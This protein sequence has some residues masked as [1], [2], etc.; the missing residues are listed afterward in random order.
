M[1]NWK[2]IA[3]GSLLAA[4]VLSAQVQ[5][6]TTPEEVFTRNLS[7]RDQMNKEFTPHK[8]IGN[9]YYV[10]TPVLG[11]YLV[12]TPAGLILI[13]SDYEATVPAIKAEVEKLGFKF[14]DIK[15]LLGSH[16]HGDHM[17]GDA[18]V[19]ELSGAQVV[20][21]AEDVPALR[22]IKPGGKEHPIDRIIHDG[23][24]VT[25][26]GTTLTAHLTPGHTKGCTTWTL[27]AEEGG[28]TYDVVIIGSAGVNPGV[29][30]VNNA[31]Y[32][33]IADDFVHTYAT[34]RSLPC[35]VPL[36]SHPAMFD[37]AGKFAK[38]QAGGPNP[39][40]DPSG[41]QIEIDINDQI[42]WRTLAAQRLKAG[43]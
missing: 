22:A 38:L 5:V 35:D 40:I 16:A 12:S 37:L 17:E 13:N 34:L 6:P 20:A 21:M 3:A 10:G 43:K 28:K 14:S 9:I 7:P 2:L 39:Y 33:N 32:P 25:L 15:I 18:M 36:G 4:S 31:D 11:S 30:L 1:T 41:Y 8:I 19:K 42:F 29:Q 26:G 27:K 23:D 24:T